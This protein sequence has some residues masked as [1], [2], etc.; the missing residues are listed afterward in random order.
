MLF[1]KRKGF[2]PI[3]DTIQKEDM[4]ND[5][6]YG[7]WNAIHVCIW[8]CNEYN[9]YSQTFKSS[10]L[11]KLFQHYWHDFF[12]LPL[13]SMP[14]N[15]KEVHKRI[16]NYFLECNWFEAYD[17]IEFTAQNC[18]NKLEGKYIKFCNVIL[19]K[20]MSA[21]RFVGNQLTDITSEEE[22]ESI[23]NA[24]KASSKYSGA[25]NHLKTSI[26]FLSDRKNPDYRNS[27]K[28]S[29]SAVESLCKIIS[30]DPKATLGS[31][32]NKIEKNH[33]L[34][35]AFKKALSNL[36]GYTNDFSGIRHALLEE[37]T[38]S[39]SDAKFMLVSCSAFINYILGKMSEKS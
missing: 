14:N 11:Y 13:D 33:E 26:D 16:R 9:H 32:L 6:R 17:F 8:E 18:P 27:V 28:E 38:V 3:K 2:S 34:H 30:D 35:P 39:Y 1:S 21:Y 4:D 15:M 29:I 19:E 31:A 5:L 37:S 25:T 36:Y 23:E 24:L 20:E 22:A 10:I 12:K 7:L